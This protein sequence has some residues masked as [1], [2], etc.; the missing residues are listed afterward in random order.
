MIYDLVI[1]HTQLGEVAV[2]KGQIVKIGKDLAPG[3]VEIDAAG[4]WLLPGGVDVHTHLGLTVGENTT[5][6]GWERGS[7]A[8]VAGGTTT[9]V[10]HIGFAADGSCRT[11]FQQAFLLA[12]GHSCCDYSLHGVAA[13]VDEE[14]LA[15][16]PAGVEEGLCSWKAYTTYDHPIYG[17]ELERLF[18]AAKAAGAVVCVHCEDDG[19]LK[20]ALA[21]LAAAGHLGP[22]YHAAS[23]PDYAEARSIREVLAAAGRA[24]D[25]PVHI[26]H[27]STAAGLREIRQARGRGQTNISV[28]TCPQYLLLDSSLYQQGR[29]L[30][31][32]AAMSPPLR[33]ADDRRAL[34][35]GLQRGD[36]DMIATDHCAFSVAQK[37]Q[38]R[39]D[40]RLTPNGAPGVEER[41]TLLISEGVGR[42]LLTLDRAA[43]LLSEAPAR[44]FG[45]E[46]KGRIA[47]GYDADLVL[48]D[49]VAPSSFPTPPAHGGA[50]YSLY[51]DLKLRGRVDKVWLRG[52]LVCDRGRV[53]ARPGQGRCV[54][55]YVRKQSGR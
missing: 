1:R 27:L 26:V 49:P 43:E 15:A 11:A 32:R 29:G 44:R 22:E 46:H 8:A 54:A 10:E 18:R 5:C 37:E 4:K 39:E 35:Q 45:L 23:R 52:E 36:I 55:R 24:G 17:E 51:S 31:L 42:G 7:Q 38:G 21:Q 20:N 30:A 12:E 34:W 3:D 6:D 33:T 53:L 48:F 41:L 2:R 14:L 25:A 19:L 13:R 9:V 50:D 16:L 47:A 40:L 28:E